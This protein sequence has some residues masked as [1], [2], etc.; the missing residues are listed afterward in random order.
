MNA[1]MK[2]STQPT[3]AH[4]QSQLRF[5]LVN[6]LLKKGTSLAVI[7]F[8]GGYL[9]HF[10]SLG[11]LDLFSVSIIFGAIFGLSIGLIDWHRTKRNFK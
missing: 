1:L 10:D 5:I 2:Q 4:Q 11:F 6:G 3:D 9:V 7:W 8:L